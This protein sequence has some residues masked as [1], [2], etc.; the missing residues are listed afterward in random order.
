MLR[1]KIGK[2]VVLGA[3]KLFDV[4][5]PYDRTYGYIDAEET[6]KGAKSQGITVNEYVERMWSSAGFTDANKG[7]ADTVIRELSEAGA[8]QLSS[9]VC[10]IG[11]GTGRYLERVLSQV[12]PSR[13]HIYETDKQWA[14]Y[15]ERQY[16]PTVIN[17][18]ANGTDLSYTATNSC[19]VVCAFGLFVYL[20]VLH[21][22]NYFEEIIRVCEPDGHIFF[23]CLTAESWD[24]PVL[25]K[26]IDCKQTYPVVLPEKLIADFFAERGCKQIHTFIAPH[27]CNIS[28][29]MVFKRTG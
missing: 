24:L 26:W 14:K 7:H 22:F 17:H 13:Y 23:D 5:S 2:L 19:G 4:T 10:E 29:Y 15:L 8:L 21:S 18:P 3:S 11:P 20:T 9:E 16:A 25:Q 12:K 6:I 28:K 27:G 1:H